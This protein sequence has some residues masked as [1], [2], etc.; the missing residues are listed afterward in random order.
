MR[1]T[2]R[3]PQ[4]GYGQAETKTALSLATCKSQSDRPL[5]FLLPL[6]QTRKQRRPNSVNGEDELS[7]P[8]TFRSTITVMKI[9]SALLLGLLP[10]VLKAQVAPTAADTDAGVASQSVT[11]LDRN[12][13]V[14]EWV[15]SVTDPTTGAVTL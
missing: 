6:Q 13:S 7:G 9:I 1:A 8:A 5:H 11:P 14:V 12:S 10:F 3:I 15:E 2:S 4:T